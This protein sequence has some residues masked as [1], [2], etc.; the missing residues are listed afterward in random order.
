MT[1]TSSAPSSTP[2]P[3]GNPSAS[4]TPSPSPNDF[5]REQKRL[6]Q[7]MLDQGV[8]DVNDLPGEVLDNFDPAVLE[9]GPNAG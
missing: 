6:A 8:S 4:S 7:A 9:A 1:E 5:Q 3:S 2:S